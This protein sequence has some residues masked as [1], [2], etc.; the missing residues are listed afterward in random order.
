M[1]I[2]IPNNLGNFVKSIDAHDKKIQGA[3]RKANYQIGKTMVQEA[4]ESINTGEKSGR[5]YTV[6]INGKKRVHQASAPGQAPAKLTGTL[7]SKTKKN[8]D[9]IVKGWRYL[10]F[11]TK[12]LYGKYLEEGTSKMAPRPYLITQVN[13]HIKDAKTWYVKYI[14]AALEK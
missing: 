5:I 8:I 6:Y 14:K 12:L 10:I 4:R 3:I 9:F 1:Q 13:K 7:S 2:K 11:G